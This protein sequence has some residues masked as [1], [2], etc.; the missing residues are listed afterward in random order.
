MAKNIQDVTFRGQTAI[1]VKALQRRPMTA[2]QMLKAT[3]GVT[4]HNSWS[5][6]RIADRAGLAFRS[7]DGSES[8]DG[9]KRYAFDPKPIVTTKRPT[10][11]TP[12]KKAAA[13]SVKKAAKKSSR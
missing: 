4:A 12:A 6:Q 2:Q 13:L 8:R 9:L 3:D 5:L 11:K 1:L 10:R 7:I